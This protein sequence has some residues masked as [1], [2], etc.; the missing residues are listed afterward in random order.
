MGG[1]RGGGYSSNSTGVHN[2]SSEL[3]GAYPIT[4]SGYFGVAGEGKVRIISSDN[5]T[6]EGKKFFDIASKG[7]KVTKL[8][9]EN[10]PRAGQVKGYKTSFPNGD[11][12]TF[13]PSTKTS[14]NPGVQLT[15]SAGQFK[16]QKIH[17]EKKDK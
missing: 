16:S 10:G 8:V 9:Y 3:L 7:G 1:G 17:F 15:V 6:I 14:K 11:F 12:V 5:P 2:N 13:R 4:K